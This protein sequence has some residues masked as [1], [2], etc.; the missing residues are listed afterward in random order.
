M[1]ACTLRDKLKAL[2]AT[3]K[4]WHK[5]VFD[6]IDYRNKSYHLDAWDL[7]VEVDDLSS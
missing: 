4:V 2:K 1:K 5:E 7:K 6:D 3:L